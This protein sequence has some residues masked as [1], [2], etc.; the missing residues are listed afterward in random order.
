MV[1]G[2]P[3]P[4]FCWKTFELMERVHSANELNEPDVEPLSITELRPEAEYMSKLVPCAVHYMFYGVRQ[5]FFKL[6]EQFSG[7]KQSD[8]II[9][10]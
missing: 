8:L 7:V 6:A 10:Q 5:H 3:T 1:L 9:A 4:I 2:P